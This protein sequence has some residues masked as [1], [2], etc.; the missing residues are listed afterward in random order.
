MDENLVFPNRDSLPNKAIQFFKNNLQPHDTSKWTD[1]DLLIL[2]NYDLSEE[3]QKRTVS[4]VSCG[5]FIFCDNSA[6]TANN[7]DKNPDFVLFAGIVVNRLDPNV[8]IYR[9]SIGE[10]NT[11]ATLQELA[12]DVNQSIYFIFQCIAPDEECLHS[13]EKEVKE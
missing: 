10:E 6:G 11:Y 1:K 3:E 5:R 2:L 8:C 12:N 13:T 4:M 9:K 7:L